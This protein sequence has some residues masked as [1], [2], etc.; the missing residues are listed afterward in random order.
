MPGMTSGSWNDNDDA[1][2]AI[3]SIVDDEFVDNIVF[4]HD[5][6]SQLVA[7]LFLIEGDNPSNR[8]SSSSSW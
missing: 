8:S 3:D 2:E 7:I 4:D 1:K 6:R 5:D